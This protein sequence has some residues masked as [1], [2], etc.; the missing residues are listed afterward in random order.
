MMR[1]MAH[2]MV[3]MQQCKSKVIGEEQSEKFDGTEKW[4]VF[5]HFLNQW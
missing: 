2:K 1:H 5:K 3:F 4:R